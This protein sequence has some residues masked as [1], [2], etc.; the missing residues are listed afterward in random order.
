MSSH[1]LVLEEMGLKA[2]AWCSVGSCSET[3]FACHRGTGTLQMIHLNQSVVREKGDHRLAWRWFWKIHGLVGLA[4]CISQ[5]QLHAMLRHRFLF[6]W[7]K[8][9][10]RSRS[11]PR[12]CNAQIHP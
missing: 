7:D 6:E 1:L 4:E 2:A 12:K 3:C 9:M 10:T 5:K 11:S 8:L